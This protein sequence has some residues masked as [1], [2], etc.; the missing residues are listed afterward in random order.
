VGYHRYGF[1]GAGR[2]RGRRADLVTSWEN[3]KKLGPNYPRPLADPRDYEPLRPDSP[4]AKPDYVAVWL[5][6][7]R[8]QVGDGE[9]ARIEERNQRK[10]NDL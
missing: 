5:E 3:T 10:R 9:A 8:Q 7:C 2:V 4:P 6:Y 1:R